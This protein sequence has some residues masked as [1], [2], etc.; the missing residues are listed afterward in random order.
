VLLL[1]GGGCCW[2]FWSFFSLSLSFSFCGVL[3]LDAAFAW[4]VGDVDG[5]GEGTG[6]LFAFPGLAAW[7]LELD[8]AGELVDDGALFSGD[9]SSFPSPAVDGG[10]L[11][12]FSSG[13]VNRSTS[14][15]LGF[16]FHSNA[17][18]DTRRVATPAVYGNFIGVLLLL[19]I[20]EEERRE[21]RDG[22][23]QCYVFHCLPSSVLVSYYLN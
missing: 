8:F 6:L 13:K 11:L 10:G 7:S 3:L 5:E 20:S 14:S 17:P 4:G 18:V 21:S 16:I 2:L 12:N 23:L 15:N 1:S 19:T 22:K 9:F